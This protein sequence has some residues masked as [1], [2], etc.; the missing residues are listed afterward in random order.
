MYYCL[1]C[2]DSHHPEAKAGKLFRTGFRTFP[3]GEKLPLG[4]CGK[5]TEQESASNKKVS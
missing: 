3:N 2:Q 5:R 4:V 1:A